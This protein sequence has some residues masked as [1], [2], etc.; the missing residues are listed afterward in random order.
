[1]VDIGSLAINIKND[2][3]EKEILQL[4]REYGIEKY[5]KKKEVI[6]LAGERPE[7]IYYIARGKTRHFIYNDDGSSKIMYFLGV[8]CLFGEASCYLGQESELNILAETEVIAYELPLQACVRLT[9]ENKSFRNRLW[10]CM[11]LKVVFLRHEIEVLLFKSCKYRLQNL[12]C[13]WV[14]ETAEE[15]DWYTINVDYSQ[16]L[17]AEIVGATRVT[18][19]RLLNELAEEGFLRTVNRK[20]QV[21]KAAC[22]K[23]CHK[24]R[25][26]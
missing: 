3:N 4:V 26:G 17:L 1:M 20:I 24:I 12:L 8:G 19:N 9:N 7:Y 15:P 22:A 16:G 18:I 21:N 2:S 11:S 14:S 5:F 6:A 10:E 23:F 25:P 13:S